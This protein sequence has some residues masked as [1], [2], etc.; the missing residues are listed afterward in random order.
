MP[1]AVA[2][3]AKNHRIVSRVSQHEAGQIAEGKDQL[4]HHVDCQVL[5]PEASIFK[6]LLPSLDKLCHIVDINDVEDDLQ[7][8]IYNGARD[9]IRA[10]SL[11]G[12]T[13]SAAEF[14]IDL[15]K[16]R[17]ESNYIT[18][19]ELADVL[20]RTENF[21]FDLA[22]N[23]V[24]DC[25]KESLSIGENINLKLLKKITRKY[26]KEISLS[27]HD[28]EKTL[29]AE[30]FIKVRDIY[31]GPAPKETRSAFIEQQKQY[32]D[33]VK[34]IENVRLLLK[35]ADEELFSEITDAVTR[36]GGNRNSLI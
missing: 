19:T 6:G 12:H 4:Q 17:S 16:E 36:K 1:V 34:W 11:M 24:S 33:D 28:L 15:L 18:V 26:N 7:P 35:D 8:A 14:N 25:V 31:G 29:S 21:S 22:H 10:V 5:E 9:A 30:N 32:K 20:V 2:N 23:I 13:L 3:V 27:K